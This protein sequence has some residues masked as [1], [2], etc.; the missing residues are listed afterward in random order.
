MRLRILLAIAA[1]WFI[2]GSTYLGVAIAVR[3]LPPFLTSGFRNVM[4]GTL[5]YGFLRLRGAARPTRSQW[6]TA[7]IV[8]AS[9]AGAFTPRMTRMTRA[10]TSKVARIRISSSMSAPAKWARCPAMSPSSVLRL[11]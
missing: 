8:G 5:L 10:Q 4:A 1:T 6:G 11:R 7:A 2:W 3:D 9:C